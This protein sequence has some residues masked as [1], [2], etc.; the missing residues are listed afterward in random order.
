MFYVVCRL[1][2]LLGWFTNLVMRPYKLSLLSF[3]VTVPK[4]IELRNISL[5]VIELS[6]V[7]LIAKMNQVKMFEYFL[8]L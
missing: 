8:T 6:K 3:S 4:T 7:T 5:E 1:L 2:E